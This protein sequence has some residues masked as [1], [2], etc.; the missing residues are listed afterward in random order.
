VGRKSEG[1]SQ[2]RSPTSADGRQ[3][4]FI[5][6]FA[7]C[8][9]LAL[10]F[11][12]EGFDAID[13]IEWDSEAAGTYRLNIDQRIRTDDIANVREVPAADIVI[14]GPPCQGFSQLGTRDPEDPRNQLWR[15]Y[16]RVLEESNA[17]VFVMEN[18]PQLIRSSQFALFRDEVARRGYAM[19]SQVLCAADYGI[20]QMRYRAIVIGSRL[21][22]PFLPVATHGPQSSGRAP[23][24]T[25][26][27]AFDE[28]PA[29]AR[30]PD[31]R[32]WHVMRPGIRPSSLV[33][34]RAVP[35]D[36]GNRF[37]MQ[38]NL[39]SIG[40]GELVPAC[41][42]R[43][44]TGTT[45]VFGRLWWDRPALTIRTEFFKPEK[46]RYLHPEADRPITVRE[47]ARLQSFPDS[48]H[49]PESQSMLSVARQIGNAVPPRLGAAIARAVREHLSE[50]TG[51]VPG[52]ETVSTRQLV[53]V[54]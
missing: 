45:D 12:W 54:S 19:R 25:V 7:G 8:G 21:G 18:V 46:G 51:G 2:L 33:R 11:R 39:D 4:T 43:K 28:Y 35:C 48:F 9:G 14:G 49:F 26:R 52:P 6:L 17:S 34:Y 32:N 30:E 53:L 42:R 24:V 23:Y 38:A 47:A 10:G 37:Q 27:Q 31:G 5:D 20:P 22:E 3:P 29:L 50:Y 41:W 1:A 44:K 15:E 13:A 36:G 16:V 40:R